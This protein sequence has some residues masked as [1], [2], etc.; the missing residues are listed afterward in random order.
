M[1][2][3][4][5]LRERQLLS[6]TRL[7]VS[8]LSDLLIRANAR[9]ATW[10]RLL[11]QAA[12]VA[13]LLCL[14]VAN[15]AVRATWSEL[16]DGVLWRA[17]GEG[18]TARVVA[19]DSP[20]ARA[21]V[22]A[23]DVLIAVNGRPVQTAGDLVEIFHGARRG[24]R[25]EYTVLRLQSQ[26]MLSVAVAPIPSGS[27]PALLRPGGSRH[28]LAAG[29]GVG[30]A[31]PPGSSGDAAFLLAVHRLLRRARL[32]VQRPARHARS[33]LLLGRRG[34][35]AD[36]AAAVPAFR[37]DVPRAAG[38]VGAQRCRPSAAAA[39][40]SA[41]AAP[42]RGASR[43]HAPDRRRGRRA[44]ERAGARRARRAAVFRRQPGRRALDHDAR[45]EARALGDVAP[46][47]A[48]DR[49]GYGARRIALLA[50]LRAAVRAELST[51]RRCP[52]AN[53]RRC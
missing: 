52:A 14:A 30:A 41:G 5:V 18:L 8:P 46:P 22:R 10:L 47:A 12:V 42:R 16:E 40:V 27:R 17:Q 11:A 51:C 35:D 44:D 25:L 4:S 37:A 3:R 19:E 53:G 31:A 32:L 20:A 9:R 24:D 33:R 45:A 50:R 15:I 49:L 43:E 28:L 36:A 39:V 48:M 7:S 2:G 21:G 29:R 23:G 1:I 26:Q 38:R 34:V 13:A 6:P